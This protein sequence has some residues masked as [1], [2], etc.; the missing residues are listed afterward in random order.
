MFMMKTIGTGFVEE[1]GTQKFQCY[2][3][4]WYPGQGFF[5]TL[6]VLTA[7][8]CVPIMLFAKPY[9]LWKADKERRESGH[10]QLV[11]VRQNSRPGIAE[12][13]LLL[14]AVVQVPV[15]LL[16]KPLILYRRSQSVD[17][18]YHTLRDEV[19]TVAM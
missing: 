11:G 1:D 13:M 19:R 6:F 3:N 16:V 4:N 18:H 10:R 14:L 8:V 7:I 9:L 17:T 15:M 12:R 5:Q 2:L